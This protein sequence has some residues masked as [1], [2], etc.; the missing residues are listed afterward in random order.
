L[1]ETRLMRKGGQLNNNNNKEIYENF[2][3]SL[4][5]VLNSIEKNSLK[6]IDFDK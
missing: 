5:P 4:S 1:R 6:K 3:G 2:N